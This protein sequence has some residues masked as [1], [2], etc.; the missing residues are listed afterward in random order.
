MQWQREM[1]LIEWRELLLVSPSAYMYL[2][3]Y[4]ELEGQRFYRF[5]SP[6]R[7]ICSYLWLPGCQDKNMSIR[8]S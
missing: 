4:E 8:E 1:L 7:E 6:K 3:E 2:R 5:Q